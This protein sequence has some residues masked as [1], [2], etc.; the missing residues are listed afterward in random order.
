MGFVLTK[1][2]EMQHIQ[3]KL[4][5]FHILISKKRMKGKGTMSCPFFL[6][7][8]MLPFFCVH[9]WLKQKGTSQK[10]YDRVPCFS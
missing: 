9:G 3:N 6:F 5:F 10:R 4:F 7:P 1:T 2:V 8:F